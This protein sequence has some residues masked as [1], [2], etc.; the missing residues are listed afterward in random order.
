MFLYCNC[1][2]LVGWW[3]FFGKWLSRDLVLGTRHSGV[4]LAWFPIQ[5]STKYF[6]VELVTQRLFYLI[7]LFA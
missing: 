1:F 5:I 2:G 7:V 3:G 4:E 6:G